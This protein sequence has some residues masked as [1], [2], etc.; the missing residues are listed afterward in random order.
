MQL[1]I[2]QFALALLTGTLLLSA[3]HK[4]TSMDELNLL[5]GWQL[6]LENNKSI[7]A[8]VPGLVHTDL[9]EAGIIPDPFYGMN[10]DSLQWIGARQWLYTLDFEINQAI[11]QKQKIQL[12][13]EGLDTYAQVKLNGTEILF[14]DNMFR[15]W[16]VDV[17]KLIRQGINRLEILFFPP[18]SISR[19][20]ARSHHI[21][22][23]DH[24]AFTRKAPFQA[25][26]DWG[27]VFHTMGIWKPVKLLAWNN[28]KLDNASV[29]TRSADTLS[30]Q[31]ELVASIQSTMDGNGLVCL[32]LDGD[33]L[34]RQKVE[35]QEGTNHLALPF[36]LMNPMLWWPNGSGKQNLTQFEL[37]F[38]DPSG[39]LHQQK[40]LSGIRKA[41]LIREPDSIG[42]GFKFRVNGKAIFALGANYIPEDH[43]VNR[44]T[45]NKSRQLL[46]DAAA[47]GMNMIRV[48]GGGIYPSDDFY[49]LCDSLGIM[50]WQDFMFA[51]TMYPWDTAF[52]E[53]VAQEAK[54]QV[55]R[56]RSHPSLVLW[57]GNNEV[58]EGFHNWG[59]QTNLG[60]SPADSQAVWQGYLAL[61]EQLLPKVVAAHDPHTAYWPSSPSLGWGQTESLKRGDVHYWGVWW[62]EEPFEVYQ[63]KVGRFNS[64]FG[65]QA[66]PSIES[67]RMFLPHNEIFIGSAGFESHQK[68]P[69]GTRLIND[70]MARDFPVPTQTEDYIYMSQLAQAH[71]IGMAIEAHRINQP[72][73]MGTLYWQLNDSWPVISWSSIDYYGRWKALH[74]WL[75]QLY[76]PTALLF[77]SNGNDIEVFVAHNGPSK[78]SGTLELSILNNNGIKQGKY[79]SEVSVASGVSSKVLSLPKERLTANTKPNAIIIE[80]ILRNKDQVLDEKIHFL[81]RPKELRLINAPVDIHQQ[82][83]DNAIELK[84]K[85][86]VFQYGLQLFSNDEEGRFSDN[87][88]H[89]I[90]GKEKTIFFYPS[91][92]TPLTRINFGKRSL[93]QF[94][95]NLR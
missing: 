10:E 23:P 82:I 77:K 36:E 8:T 94:I 60:W 86:D 4:H 37:E 72:V 64:E 54:H 68:H 71:G 92:K 26:W 39:Q 80:A 75:K 22:L 35:L 88:I 38:T 93:N 44:I 89:L 63:Q 43:F 18:D 2:T 28:A 73:T 6:Y 76:K 90:T 1:K 45:R 74:F 32:K 33:I 66:M 16:Q 41:E 69:R 67:V 87:F 83:R 11:L 19:E 30:A 7:A 56:F 55:Q 48:W 52:L 46:S 81:V 3:C 15:M 40:I 34:L 78:L 12:I 21:K 65:F 61:F 25:G 14:A 20:K 79:F 13:F 9:L 59:W 50:V 62:G 49:E 5:H 70:Y 17:K 47:V 29:I 53:N 42:E 85:S 57:C 31:L 24:R 84:L 91:G 58:S 95:D 27:P 51:C